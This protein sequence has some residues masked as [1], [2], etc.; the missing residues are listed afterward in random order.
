MNFNVAGLLRDAVG[1]AREYHVHERLNPADDAFV[2][3][4]PVEGTVRLTRTQRGVLVTARLH[5]T[6]SQA[7]SRCLEEVAN[8]VALSVE[9]E[10]VQT[11]D[12]A[13]GL[14]LSTPPKED[15]AVL[16][17]DHHEISLDEL[18]RQYL[19]TELPMQPLC[20]NDCRGLCPRCGHNLNEGLCPCA[21]PA[22]DSRWQVLGDLLSTQTNSVA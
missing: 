18:L 1:A 4:S 20:R 22:A 16:I 19:L 7:C 10:F 13:T 17:D 12:V 9:E 8:Q 6:A 5:S 11:L 3:T 2:L 21:R 14:E 15:P